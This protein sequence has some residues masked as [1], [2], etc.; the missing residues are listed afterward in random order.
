MINV[1]EDPIIQEDWKPGYPSGSF[2]FP[3]NLIDF[4]AV[5]GILFLFIGISVYEENFSVL[6]L[7]ALV[8]FLYTTGIL[9]TDE[10]QRS[11]MVRILEIV[12]LVLWIFLMPYAEWNF[13]TTWIV[14]SLLFLK[15]MTT[16]ILLQILELQDEIFIPKSEAVKERLENALLN[17]EV[18]DYNVDL[19]EVLDSRKAIARTILPVGISIYL[20]I[21]LIFFLLTLIP[22][23]IIAAVQFVFLFYDL[24]VIII[25]GIFLFLWAKQTRLRRTKPKFM[26]KKRRFWKKRGGDSQLEAS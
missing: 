8:L 14:A 16:S 24:V 19:N 18:T 15:L 26:K 11:V 7:N 22:R 9:L 20:F 2:Y 12:F 21:S 10:T 3:Y 17:L 13:V 5:A 23:P 25:V 4:F 6:F 1:R